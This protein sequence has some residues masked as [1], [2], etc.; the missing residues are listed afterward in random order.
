MLEAS[1]NYEAPAKVECVATQMLK[2]VSDSTRRT[3]EL[4]SSSERQD[5]IMEITGAAGAAD[6]IDGGQANV[7]AIDAVSAGSDSSV[8][9]G[10]ILLDALPSREQVL[11]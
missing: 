1:H 9:S 10:E 2:K 8:L 3:L 7:A 11:A 5:V 4:A 6:G